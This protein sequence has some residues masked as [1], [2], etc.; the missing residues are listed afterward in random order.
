MSLWRRR[1]ALPAEIETRLQRWRELAKVDLRQ[2]ADALRWVVVDVESSG[3]N[4]HRDRLLSIGAAAVVAGRLQLND[5]FEVVL[6]QTVPSSVDNILVHGI[7]GGRQMAGETADAGLLRFL[8]YVGKS[9]V[10]AFHAE[11]DRVLIERA[12]DSTLSVRLPNPWLDLA[13]LT[14]ALFD[15]AHA[16]VRALDDWTARFGI[17]N[18]ARHHAV[19]DAVATAELMLIDLAAAR[20]RG[21]TRG[22]ALFDLA[23]L[24][25]ERRAG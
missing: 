10:V 21:V 13:E 2:P 4:P 3:L 20:A 9:P 6:K 1:Q 7:G 18:P 11:F 16:P 23:R 12:L 17:R 25:R 8:E 15:E 19:A 5:S 24:W 14:P 22:D